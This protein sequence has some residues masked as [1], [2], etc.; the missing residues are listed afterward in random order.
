DVPV[1]VLLSGGVDS[2]VVA[3]LARRVGAEPAAFTVAF[4]GDGATGPES[5][6]EAARTIARHVGLRH[7]ERVLGPEALEPLDRLVH[8]FGAPFADSSAIPMFH[9]GQLAAEHGVK[10]VLTGDGGDEVFGGYSNAQAAYLG[11][12]CRR[13]ATPLPGGIP[14]LERAAALAD[15]LPARPRWLHRVGTVLRHAGGDLRTALRWSDGWS[16]SALRALRGPALRDAAADAHDDDALLVAHA[17]AAVG[18]NDVERVLYA[19]LKVI[20]PGDYLVKVDVALMASSVEGRSPFL[21]VET[22]ELGARIPPATKLSPLRTKHLL[23]RVALDLGLPR[24]P[25]LRPKRGF[26][27]PVGAWLRGPLRARAHDCLLGTLPARGVVAPET[28]RHAWDA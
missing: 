17:R 16:G 18:A 19:D 10:V 8:A 21:D 24:G 23:K 22:M 5:D 6:L 9:A 27:A 4:A 7:H 28:V 20:L 26:T 1:G 13:L 11:W 2:S 14:A 3:G 15:R 12:L 25:L